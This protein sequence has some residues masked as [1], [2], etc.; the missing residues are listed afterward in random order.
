MSKHW[1]SREFIGEL[2][3]LCAELGLDWYVSARDRAAL[4]ILILVRVEPGHV[5]RWVPAPREYAPRGVVR[6]TF[7]EAGEDGYRGLGM[8]EAEWREAPA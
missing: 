8:I 1:V 6:Y 2:I 5:S 4:L 7:H 3:T